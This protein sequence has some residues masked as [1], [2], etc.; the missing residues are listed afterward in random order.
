MSAQLRHCPTDDD[1]MEAAL[2]PEPT[3]AVE[4]VRAAVAWA[5]ENTGAERGAL[6]VLLGPPATGKTIA[7]AHAVMHFPLQ[8]EYATAAAFASASPAWRDVPTVRFFCEVPLLAI[9]DVGADMDPDAAARLADLLRRRCDRGVLTLVA[10][11]LTARGFYE[12]F[13]EERLRSR[14]LEQAEGGLPPLHA[15]GPDGHL[16]IADLSD[17]GCP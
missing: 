8:A 13:G 12:R 10:S 15:V 6:A 4:A 2:A 1:T 11:N 9:D 5:R 16:T 3:A 17:P 14:L 7:L